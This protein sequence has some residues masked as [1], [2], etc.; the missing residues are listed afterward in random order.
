MI[1]SNEY[2]ATKIKIEQDNEEKLKHY[3]ILQKQLEIAKSALEK[4]ASKIDLTY[5]D[6]SCYAFRFYNDN[7]REAQKALKEIEEL[8]KCM[9]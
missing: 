2:G 3:P 7:G 9:K 5:T 4:Y 8:N 6:G 1:T